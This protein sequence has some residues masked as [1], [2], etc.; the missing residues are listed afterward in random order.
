MKLLKAANPEDDVT[1]EVTVWPT[2]TRIDVT[3]QTITERMCVPMMM[4]AIF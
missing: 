3:D 1:G 2:G 4:E